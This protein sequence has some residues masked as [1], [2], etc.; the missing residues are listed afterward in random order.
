MA[1]KADIAM[2][3]KPVLIELGQLGQ[4]V[5][6]AVVIKAGQ[7][8]PKFETPPDGAERSPKLFDEFWQCD[9][10]FS[11]PVPEQTGSRILDRFHGEEGM[12]VIGT[13][14]DNAFKA[15]IVCHTE[16]KHDKEKA[17]DFAEIKTPNSP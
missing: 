9:H 5:K 1:G 11:P 2:K 16:A 15:H 6:A 8:A 7:G 3:P 12:S 13:L 17:N 10:L 4:G 14:Y